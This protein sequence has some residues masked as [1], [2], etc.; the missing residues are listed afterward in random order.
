MPLVACLGWGSL[1]WDPRGLPIQ[2]EWFT[3]GPSVQVEFLRESE[4]GRITLVLHSSA[5][6]VRSLWAVMKPTT[7]DEAI[8]ALRDREGIPKR[9]TARNVG[10]WSRGDATPALL[11]DLAEWAESRGLDAVVWTALS[12]KFRGENGRVPSVE[13]T[14]SYLGDLRGEVRAEAELYV[15][16]APRQIDTPYRRAIEAALAWTPFPPDF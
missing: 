11:T 14:V 4:N 10:M 12:A 9:Y 5:Q 15:R 8:E 1:V 16:R 13:E 3:D 2:T 6:A 7:L